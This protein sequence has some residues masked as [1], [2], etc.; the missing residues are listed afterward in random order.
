[1]VLAPIV[2]SFALLG[3]NV[4]AYYALL[5]LGH[6]RTVAWLNL[7]GGTMMLLG[8]VWLLPR[9]GVRGVAMARLAYGSIALFMYYPLAR[10]FCRASHTSLP[11][12]GAYAVCEDA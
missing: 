9:F 8:M 11:S 3:I 2:W 12:A 4:T 10:L 7:A 1:M 5:A 6:V